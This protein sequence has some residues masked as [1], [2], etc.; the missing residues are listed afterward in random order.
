[1][2]QSQI[3]ENIKSSVELLDEIITD[4][5]IPKNIRI[6]CEKTKDVLLEEGDKK[7]KIDAAIQNLDLLSDNLNVP[8]YTRMQIWNIVSLLES[9]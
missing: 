4:K 2:K 8:T 6:V 5:N 1:M 3:E 9:A 7:I